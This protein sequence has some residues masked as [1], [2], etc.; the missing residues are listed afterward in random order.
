MINEKK[1]EGISY[2]NDESDRNGMRIIVILKQ[3]LKVKVHGY[4]IMQR[5]RLLLQIKRVG[6]LRVL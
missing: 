3:V 5:I 4:A 1:I 6:R 2:I